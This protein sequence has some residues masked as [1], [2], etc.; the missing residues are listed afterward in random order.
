[1]TNLVIEIIVP[2]ASDD[3]IAQ[4]SVL[5]GFAD[6]MKAFTDALPDGSRHSAR[7]V[8]SRVDAG[9]PR[10]PRARRAANNGAAAAQPPAAG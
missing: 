7:F 2:V 1:M 5:H 10:A 3:V 9:E 8:K 6:A 4:A